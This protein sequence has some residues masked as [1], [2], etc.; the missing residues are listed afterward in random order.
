MKEMGVHNL[1]ILV[2]W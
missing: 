2:V 1:F